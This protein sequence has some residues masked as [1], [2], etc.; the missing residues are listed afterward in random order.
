[1]KLEDK[2]Q[3]VIKRV[4]NCAVEVYHELGDGWPEGIYHKSMEVA[5]RLAGFPYETQR[6]LPITYKGFVVGES[7]PDLVV[8]IEDGKNRVGVVIDLKWE[9]GIQENHSAQ[10]AKYIRELK[11]QIKENESVYPCGYVINF[12]KSATSK[13][14]DEEKLECSQGVQI[15]EVK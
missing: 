12:L 8:W 15:L 4:K 5:L 9:P 14:I 13:K 7:I 1:M 3:E 11:K 6:I 10:V 2:V